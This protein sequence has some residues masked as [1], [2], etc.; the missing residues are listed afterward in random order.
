MNMGMTIQGTKELQAMLHKLET[1]E[2]RRVA[3]TETRDGLKKTMLPAVASNAKS[4]VGGKIGNEIA[5][6][7]TVRAMTKMHRGS[8]GHKVIIKPTDAFVYESYAGVRSYIPNAI[9]YGHAAPNDAGGTKIAEPIKFQ[10]QAYEEKRRPLA[11]LVSERIMT[12]IVKAAYMEL[13]NRRG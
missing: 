8:Y 7:L 4:M 13:R 5:K 6:N 9:E 1:K 10:R 3:R 12:Q 11:K 2:V